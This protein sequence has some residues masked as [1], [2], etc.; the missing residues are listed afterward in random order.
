[1]LFAGQPAPALYEDVDVEDI[2]TNVGYNAEDNLQ[3]KC[4]C[5]C[6][7]VITIIHT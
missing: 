2:M 1:M 7:N 4:K 3:P 6:F 5:L